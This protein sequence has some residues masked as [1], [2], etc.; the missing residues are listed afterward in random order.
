MLQQCVPEIN[1]DKSPL[2][3][4]LIRPMFF[5]KC[6]KHKKLEACIM[7]DVREKYTGVSDDDFDGTDMELRRTG[8]AAKLQ[9]DDVD[10][11]A[12]SMYEFLYGSDSNMDLD[13][14]L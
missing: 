13:S 3:R 11:L 10:A 12:S 4:E 1:K 14:I 7:K 9:D 2:S 8:K 6:Y 5:F